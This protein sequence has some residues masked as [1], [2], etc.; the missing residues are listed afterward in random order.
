M[1]LWSVPIATGTRGGSSQAAG[2]AVRMYYLHPDFPEY[3]VDAA[4][5]FILAA[6]A[7]DAL[8]H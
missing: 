6:N 3:V 2:F 5:T 4:T 7:A 1:A 8:T